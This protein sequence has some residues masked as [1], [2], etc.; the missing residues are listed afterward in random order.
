M[1]TIKR[2][3]CH[4]D[5]QMKNGENKRHRARLECSSWSSYWLQ[6]NVM[7]INRPKISKNTKDFF[8]FFNS[9]K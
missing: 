2:N 9:K 3:L 5:E 1:I 4:Q 8:S 7:E 6:F